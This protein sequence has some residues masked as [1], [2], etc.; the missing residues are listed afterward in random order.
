MSKWE[1]TV[2]D[3]EEMNAKLKEN[4]FARGTEGY[5][6]VTRV[7]KET[8]AEI[9]GD[10]AYKAGYEKRDS[11]F[12][13]NPDY[14]DFQKGVK[15]GRELGRREVVEWGNGRCEHSPKRFTRRHRCFKCWQG[16]LKEW[17]LDEN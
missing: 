17:G 2:V 5:K 7:I 3:D 4:D 11:E 14:L 9:T 13:Y 12:V 15:T 6:Q 10:I 16:K 8:Q 1:E